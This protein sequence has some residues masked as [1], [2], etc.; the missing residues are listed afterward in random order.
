MDPNEALAMLRAAIRQ[1]H[2]SNADRMVTEIEALES[3]REYAVALDSWL[4]RGG[5]LPSAWERA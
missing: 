3:V 4:S 1:S 2:Q 5:F